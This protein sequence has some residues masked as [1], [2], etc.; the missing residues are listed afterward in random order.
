MSNDK[1]E[2]VKIRRAPKFIPFSLTGLLLGAVIAIAL[3]LTIDNPDGKTPGF[4]A[5]LLVYC[6]GAGACFGLVIAV[7]V[8]FISNRRA[9]DAQASKVSKN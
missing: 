1:T 5:Q 8:D 7:V 2:T 6:L 4:I 3:S 9:K